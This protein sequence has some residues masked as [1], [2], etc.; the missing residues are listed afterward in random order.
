MH[1]FAFMRKLDGQKRALRVTGLITS[2]T[3]DVLTWQKRGASKLF[4]SSKL[5]ETRDGMNKAWKA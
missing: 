2:E 1:A 3:A 4:S 5:T